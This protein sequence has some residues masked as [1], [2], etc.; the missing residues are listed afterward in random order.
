ME[1]RK[2]GMGFFINSLFPYSVF[3]FDNS[4]YLKIMND[5]YCEKN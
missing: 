3:C 1:F 4:K 2:M 5:A